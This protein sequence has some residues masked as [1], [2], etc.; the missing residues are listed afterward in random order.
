MAILFGLNG[1][2]V[3]GRALRDEIFLANSSTD[4]IR[5]HQAKD[6]YDSFKLTSLYVYRKGVS[7]SF[8][9]QVLAR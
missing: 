4:A 9:N 1:Y 8:E 2:T 6:L 7:K 5:A 3:C